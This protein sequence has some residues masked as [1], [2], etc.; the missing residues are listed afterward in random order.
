MNDYIDVA[1]LGE[2]P[3]GRPVT[4]M[5]GDRRI[6]LCRTASGVHALDNTCPHRG[7]PLG[8]GDLIGEELV[9]PWHLWSFDVK[10]GNCPG[11]TSVGVAA[12]DVKVEEGRV[13]VRLAP[14]RPLPEPM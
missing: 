10:S 11:S 3:Q 12:H 8:E 7:G 4:R 13:L 1:A 9:C 2:I 14:P 6:A 5:A